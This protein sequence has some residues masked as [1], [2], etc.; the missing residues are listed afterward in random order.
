VALQEL[1]PGVRTLS[2]GLETIVEL[3]QTFAG[4]LRHNCAQN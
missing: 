4:K 2:Q 1:L 3:P